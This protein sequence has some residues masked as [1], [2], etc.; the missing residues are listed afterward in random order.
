M[1]PSPVGSLPP[2]A[3]LEPSAIN[4]LTASAALFS[5]ISSARH[6]NPWIPA[7]HF[8]WPHLSLYVHT[9]CAL[10]SPSN[11]NTYLPFPHPLR[12]QISDMILDG[13][14]LEFYQW[15][16]SLEEHMT[17]VKKSLNEVAEAR[18]GA[19]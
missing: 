4:L 13:H 7:P 18:A 12:I 11:I 16:G 14:N 3:P 5:A 8:A 6:L 10:L 2:T 15:E 17:A 9:A 1:A 19:D